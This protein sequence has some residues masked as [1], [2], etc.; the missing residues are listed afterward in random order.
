MAP[1][2]LYT[3]VMPIFFPRR[4]GVMASTSYSHAR[5]RSETIPNLREPSGSAAGLVTE[6]KPLPTNTR[7]NTRRQYVSATRALCGGNGFLDEPR[8]L[9][10]DTSTIMPLKAG[11]CMDAKF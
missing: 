11:A 1:L 10:D 7:R 8:G 9:K 4:A 5:D 6:K 2:S 3:R